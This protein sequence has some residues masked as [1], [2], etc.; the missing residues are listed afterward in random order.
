MKEVT[1][2][3]NSGPAKERA[4]LA[5]TLAESIK[6]AGYK[7]HIVVIGDHDDFPKVCKTEV[8]KAKEKEGIIVAAGGD[9]TVNLIAGLCYRHGVT[10]G[11]IPMG[12]FN[13]F[14]RDLSIPT[15]RDEAVKI[16]AADHTKQVTVGLVQD[17]IFLNNASFGLYTKL[18]RER[19]Q[20]SSRFGRVRIIAALAAAYSLFDNHKL[21]TIKINADGKEGRHTTPMVFVGNNTLQLEN[22]GLEVATH[23]RQD[24]LAVIIMK[25][26]SRW[27]IARLLFRGAIKNL[28]DESRLKE[29][30]AD[31]FEVE[32]RRKI[33][34]LVIDGE[35]IRC[36]TP[37][38]FKVDK[39]TLTVLVPLEEKSAA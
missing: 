13:Y 17:R 38:E 26:S 2:I 22:L 16:I 8:A 23:T 10:L 35:I 3:L 12:T 4:K 34:N 18:I 9:G 30:C 7:A 11:I 27:E 19:E 21:F 15:D 14:A 1:V 24:Q 31:H 39:K 32:S 25:E 6:K 37:L 5:E 28:K 20:A 36:N 33:I 29:F